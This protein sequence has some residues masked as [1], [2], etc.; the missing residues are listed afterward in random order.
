MKKWYESGLENEIIYIDL[1]YGCDKIK[2]K[3]KH[4]ERRGKGGV[5]MRNGRTPM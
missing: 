5:F 3:M 2:N 1:L 4:F